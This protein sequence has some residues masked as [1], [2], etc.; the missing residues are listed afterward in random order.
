MCKEIHFKT[1]Q[2]KPEA[3]LLVLIVVIGYKARH[4]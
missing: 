2:G 4:K 1:T 3:Q